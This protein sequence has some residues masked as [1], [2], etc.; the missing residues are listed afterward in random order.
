MSRAG[1]AGEVG[2]V[3]RCAVA[4]YMAVHGLRS[5]PI[6]GLD[7]PTGVDPVRLD[8]ETSDP[9]DD[10]CVT[11]SDGRRAYVSAK[12]KVTRGRP[13]A[14]T[15]AGWAS[16]ASSL[17]PD[18]LLIL[19]G[20]EFVGPTKNLDHVLRRH[21]AGLPMETKGENG[22]LAVLTQLLGVAGGSGRG[23]CG[24]VCPTGH[25]PSLAGAPCVKVRGLAWWASRR[26]GAST[27]C[28]ERGASRGTPSP[29][30]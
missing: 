17:G 12:R 28:E 4:T 6:A 15:V 26:R 10:I 9:T 11:F 14:E 16:Q 13:L 19:A 1:R 21:R 18:D 3:F 20:E 30:R 27:T 29:S 7:L 25:R 23:R 24:R 2:S 5:Q 8:F 22:A